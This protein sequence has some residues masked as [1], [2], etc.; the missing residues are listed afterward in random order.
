MFLEIRPLRLIQ[1]VGVRRQDHRQ[2]GISPRG[3]R[4]PTGEA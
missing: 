4:G 1:W 2:F 3:Q